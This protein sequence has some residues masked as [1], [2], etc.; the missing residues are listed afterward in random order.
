MI[1]LQ[2]RP[3]RTDTLFPY[4]TLFRSPGVVGTSAGLLE[5]TVT[6]SSSST[7]KSTR[8]ESTVVVPAPVSKRALAVLLMVEPA[9]VP[10]ASARIGCAGAARREMG[11]QEGRSRCL[12]PPTGA[13]ILLLTPNR[14]VLGPVSTASR[15]LSG[16]MGG[17]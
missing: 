16:W 15:V 6:S 7:S 14:S 13:N 1:R 12:A 4:T 3:T 17:R 2:P 5:S 11:E 9:R 10:A 8:F